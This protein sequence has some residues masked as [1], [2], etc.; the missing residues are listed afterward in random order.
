MSLSR[1]SDT[2]KHSLKVVVLVQILD[3][4]FFLYKIHIFVTRES[5]GRKETITVTQRN[6]TSEGLTT[7]SFKKSNRNC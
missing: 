3:L 5:L 2:T 7:S 4:L 1:F 6:K